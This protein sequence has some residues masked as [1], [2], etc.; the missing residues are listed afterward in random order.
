MNKKIWGN[1]SVKWNYGLR[2][3]TILSGYWSV[4]Y[5]SFICPLS[6]YFLPFTFVKGFSFFFVD[7]SEGDVK[8]FFLS[9][10]K[11]TFHCLCFVIHVIFVFG[12]GRFHVVTVN[13]SLVTKWQLIQM[14]IQN[15]QSLKTEKLDQKVEWKCGEQANYFMRWFRSSHLLTNYMGDHCF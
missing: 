3:C 12:V 11:N 14:I 7:F 1:S 10:T 15:Q 9:W 4:F 5:L 8:K 2:S 6:C 13:A